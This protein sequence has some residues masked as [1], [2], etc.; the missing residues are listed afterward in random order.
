[1]ENYLINYLESKKIIDVHKI[2]KLSINKYTSDYTEIEVF[3][4]NDKNTINTILE[5]LTLKDYIN[6]KFVIMSMPDYNLILRDDK[7][8]HIK[9][10]I[11]SEANVLRI[12]N[13]GSDIEFKNHFLL[14]LKK[15]I[16]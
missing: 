16:N 6:K 13:V 2:S 14:I 11:I 15:Y 12:K 8:N 9:I 10:G 5:E 4:T 7:L 3:K 1:M